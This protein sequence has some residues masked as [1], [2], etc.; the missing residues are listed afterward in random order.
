MELTF[1]YHSHSNAQ[2]NSRLGRC[3]GNLYVKLICISLDFGTIQKCC[4]IGLWFKTIFVFHFFGK[5]SIK[6]NNMID[7]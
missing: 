4:Q 7:R 2:G 5:I 3:T 6:Q 1:Q